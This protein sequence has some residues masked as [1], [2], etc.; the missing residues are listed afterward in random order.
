MLLGFTLFSGA[1]LLTVLHG[2]VANGPIGR[3][4]RFG[5]LRDTGRISYGLYLVHVPLYFV[6]GLMGRPP[7]ASAGL[8]TAAIAVIASFLLAALS[9]RVFERPILVRVGSSAMK[10]SP[11]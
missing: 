10:Y 2:E 4:F 3:I 8:G 5:F 9:F 7:E 6:F 1:A 11:A